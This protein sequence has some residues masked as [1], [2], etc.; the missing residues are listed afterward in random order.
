MECNQ[1]GYGEI[2]ETFNKVTRSYH[3]AVD[4]RYGD[5]IDSVHDWYSNKQSRS[6]SITFI[7]MQ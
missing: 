1:Y 6:K 2:L 7:L 3:G 4:E 5:K